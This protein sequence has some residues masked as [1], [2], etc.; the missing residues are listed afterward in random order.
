M[1]LKGIEELYQAGEETREETGIPREGRVSR[2][3]VLSFVGSPIDMFLFI[4]D[5]V[6]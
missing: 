3:V 1:F 4:F 2:F 5:I 6:I